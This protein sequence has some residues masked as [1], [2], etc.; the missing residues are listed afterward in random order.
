MTVPRLSLTH[1]VLGLLLPLL[2]AAAVDIP[3]T[4]VPRHLAPLFNATAVINEKF[5][6][7]SLSQYLKLGKWVVLL[8]YPYGSPTHRRIPTA[9][10]RLPSPPLTVLLLSSAPVRG[11]LHV[12]VSHR[13]PGLQ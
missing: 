7:I 12:C 2:L 13:D 5:E 3:S 8:F 4:S 6:Q 9:A 1:C 10:H 11:R